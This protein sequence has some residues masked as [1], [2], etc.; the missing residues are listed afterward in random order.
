M[1]KINQTR[2]KLRKMQNVLHK[3]KVLDGVE[4]AV[5]LLKERDEEIKV[6]AQSIEADLQGFFATIDTLL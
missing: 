5:D 1:K 4:K 2:A 6:S 3:T